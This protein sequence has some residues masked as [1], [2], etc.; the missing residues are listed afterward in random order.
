MADPHEAEFGS[1]GPV[2][3]ATLL[4]FDDGSPAAGVTIRAA[5][6]QR[7][8]E[9]LEL[10]TRTVTVATGDLAARNRALRRANGSYLAV[11]EPGAVPGP[12]WLEQAI[13]TLRDDPTLGI[14]GVGH[15]DGDLR[16]DLDARILV[17]RRTAWNAMGGFASDIGP[18]HR[19]L[20][21]GWRCWL[22]GWR[23]RVIDVPGTETAVPPERSDADLRTLCARL[24][25]D[26]QVSE[27]K[28][29]SAIARTVSRRR[30][31]RARRRTDADLGV[32]LQRAIERAG[33]AQEL[34]SVLS[35]VG[36]DGI[37]D[38]RRRVVV[39]TADTLAPVMAGPGIRAW[40]LAAALSAEHD[41]HLVT[42]G[43][44]DLSDARFS[45]EAVDH[46]RFVELVAASDIVVFQGWIMADRPWLAQSEVTIVC[47]VYD[48]MHLEQLEQGR[49]APAEGGRRNAITDTTEVMNQQFRR[50]DYFL[51]ASRKQRDFYL[52]QLSAVGRINQVLYDEDT[53]L[54]E[55]MRVVPFGI[56]DDPPSS[57]TGA[58]RG[59]VDGIGPDDDI[60]L[61]GGGI[62]NWFDPLTLIRAVEGLRHRRPRL[63]LYFLGTRHPN[64]EI[65][66][67]RMA[68]AARRLADE[69]G[70]TGIHVFFNDGWVAFE[71]RADYLLDADVA[72]SIHEQHIETEYSFRTRILDYLWCALPIVA[73]SGDS[74][75][76]LIHDHDLGL[77]VEPH[78]VDGLEA[79][80]ESLLSDDDRRKEISANCAAFAEQF[81]WASVL[82]PVMDICRRPRRAPDVA[83]P[84]TAISY[85]VT[86][87]PPAWRE[88]LTLA[89]RYLAEGGLPLVAKRIRS[90]VD[91]LRASDD[92]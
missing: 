34:G 92:D 19:G 27:S 89:R 81:R 3:A 68:A 40:R 13:A 49:D 54:T 45:V 85:G 2:V 25:R 56:D 16:V 50:G 5:G 8:P 11:L 38:P 36:A 33:P 71:E 79:A 35:E 1:D 44:C 9:A 20:D 22:L 37:L 84:D 72:V 53:S 66:E 39:A 75:A 41:V 65:P 80:L 64:P 77:V 15:P 76:P 42:T 87:R 21:L 58:L 10:L 46:D 47:D 12:G 63:R 52:G 70:L 57:A 60:V 24:L 30:L 61:W 82:E 83:C 62:Y 7:A 59:V 28:A 48:P 86:G 43:R 90:R 4:V 88:D 55:R 29:G 18:G 32:L 51:C 67:M 23:A 6:A 17:A 74:F 14:V 73:T 91:R 31:Q 78:D 69:L 26:P